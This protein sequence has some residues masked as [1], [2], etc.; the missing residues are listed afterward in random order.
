M[1]RAAERACYLVGALLLASGLIH[2]LI[3][4]LSGAN[5]VGP[6]SLRKAMTFGLSFGLTLITIGWVSSFL[7]IRDRLRTPL[8]GVFAAISVVETVLVSMQAWRGVPSHF[9]LETTFD[10]L[11][12]R[13]LAAG[14]VALVVIIATL[15][16]LAFRSNRSVPSVMR[17]AIRSGF[18]ILLASMVIGALMIAKGMTLVFAGHAQAAYASAGSLKPAHGVMMHGI[19]VLPL[20]AWVM[21][22]TDWTEQTQRRV[23]VMATIAYALMAGL[24]TM[25]II[26]GDMGL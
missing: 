14:G 19:L 8:L 18:A 26:L 3:L 22:L 1:T 25:S 10:G 16:F 24:L 21:M 23:V 15:T 17:I 9:N 5:W 7:E 13:A 6:L 4:L 11:V 2:L 20:L 12:A